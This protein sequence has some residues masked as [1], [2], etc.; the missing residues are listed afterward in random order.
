MC[1]VLGWDTTQGG[2]KVDGHHDTFQ[3]MHFSFL[4]FV[5]CVMIDHYVA[6]FVFSPLT[7]CDR[8][9]VGSIFALYKALMF[10]W[11]WRF[12]VSCEDMWIKVI[13]NI[14]GNSGRIGK[15]SFPSSACSPWIA[16]LKATKHLTEKSIDLISLVY[17]LDDAKS[18]TVVER[19]RLLDWFS[20]LRRPPRGARGFIDDVILDF[21]YVATRW[22]RLVPAKVNVFFWRLNLNRIPTRV[23]L[24]RRGIDIGSV[25]CPVY[26]RDVE[27]SNHLLF[28]CEMAVDLWVLV[29]RW[30][31][32]DIPVTS[33]VSEWVA[34][35]DSVRLPSKVRNCLDV[36]ALTLMGSIWCFRN[37]LLFSFTKTCLGGFL[38][39]LTVSVYPLNYC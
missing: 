35:I 17:A 32:L 15:A 19:L 4:Y 18:C 2:I 34:W 10:K 24:D 14:H 5:S 9:G 13:K 22:N 26:D 16:I 36:V 20:I 37:K 7:G 27:T 39:F 33:S 3:L 28:S 11:I 6:F 8:L 30:W 1:C 29:A 38:G 25:L 31:E 23:N 12:R 21:D